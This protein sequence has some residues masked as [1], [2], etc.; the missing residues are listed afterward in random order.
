[1]AYK[2]THFNTLGLGANVPIVTGNLSDGYHALVDG[3]FITL[4]VPYPMGFFAKWGEGRNQ[5]HAH[6]VPQRGRH[7][8]P[9]ERGAV[10]DAAGSAG[11]VTDD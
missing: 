9:A 10:S 5:F 2:A 8:E 7:G 4:R 6:A 3:K 1:M 11:A